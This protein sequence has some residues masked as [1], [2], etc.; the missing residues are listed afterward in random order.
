MA[1]LRLLYRDVDRTPYL[2]TLRQCARQYGLE[3]DVVRAGLGAGG[4]AERLESEEVDVIAENYWGLQNDRARGAPFVAFAA[5]SNALPE[6]LLVDSSVQSIGDLRGK[7]LAVRGTGPQTLFPAMWLKDHGLAQDVE[8]VVYSER[9]TGRWG[10]WKKVV[11][12]EC[13][14]C[15]VTDL[16]KDAPLAAGLHE[17]PYELYPFA[18][19]NVTLTTTEGV[20]R[21][22][23]PELQSLVDA[24]FATN[25]AFKTD[26]A[27]V[28][29]IIREEALDLLR[30]HFDNPDDAWLE[31]AH[32]MLA[33]E[34]ADIPVP[35]VEGI[36]NAIRIQVEQQRH[37]QEF[38]PL[39]MWDFSFAR[40]AMER[41]GESR[42]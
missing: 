27:M 31:K 34:L 15:F 40:E 11:T 26:P 10:H 41:T 25:R 39:L 3:L 2:F 37:L 7:K 8:Q 33:D 28:L 22:K 32:R 5:V 24:A 14:A 29:K 12:G 18:G 1:E 21:R 20:I 38:N 30:E 9:D 42:G 35:T 17:I 36:I 16:Y 4:W 23:R 19:G 6:R 13:Q